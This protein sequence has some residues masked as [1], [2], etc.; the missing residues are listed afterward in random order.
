MYRA[1]YVFNKINQG[2]KGIVKIWIG[3]IGTGKKA[4]G[5]NA[6]GNICTRQ[7]IYQV[8]YEQV[9]EC[10]QVKK[11]EVKNVQGKLCT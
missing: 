11:S 3:K 8:K 9:S 4:K 1:K 10:R 6:K 7:C 2:K 5:K